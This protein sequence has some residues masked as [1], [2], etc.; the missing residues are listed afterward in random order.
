MPV[1]VLLNANALNEEQ[2]AEVC[3]ISVRQVYRLRDQG[4]LRKG[5]RGYKL[6]ESVQSYV[7]HREEIIRQA[8][9]KTDGGYNKARERRMRAQ[10]IV[11]ELRA[12][13][14][15]GRLLRG[16]AVDREVMNV[17]SN[18]RS[19]L[20]ALPSRVTHSLLPHVAA[21]TGNANFQAIHQI[22]TAD[23]RRSLSEASKLE[24]NG[25]SRQKDRAKRNGTDDAS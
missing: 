3:G 20:M 22:V 25:I 18:V 13:E 24:A 10:A 15:E 12:G 14:L 5:R 23:V 1:V 6:N 9:S 17:L 8:C 7:R 11:E 2:I 4:V 21:E 19:H 16:D